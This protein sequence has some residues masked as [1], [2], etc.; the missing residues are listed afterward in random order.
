MRFTFHPVLRVEERG[1]FGD[2]WAFTTSAGS[3]LKN[4][5]VSTVEGVAN[6]AKGGYKLATDGEAREKAWETTK[7][8]ASKVKDY[9]SKAIDDPE[10]ALNDARAGA[11]SMYN[12]FKAAKDKAAAEGRS[13]E[14]W[15]NITGAGVFEVGTMLIPVGAASKLGKAGKVAD[16][17]SDMGK[18]VDKVTD[19]AKATDK[20]VDA[21]KAVTAA[22]KL[23]DVGS[24][25]KRANQASHNPAI[26]LPDCAHG[27]VSECPLKAK[28]D[29]P[30]SSKSTPTTL[31]AL[32]SHDMFLQ[33]EVYKKAQ[34]NGWPKLRQ[35]GTGGFITAKPEIIKG[36]VKLYRVN[37]S[38]NGMGGWWS[39]NP[40]PAT[41]LQWRQR[42]AVLKNWNAA[43]EVL[44]MDI[45]AGTEIKVWKGPGAPASDG[46]GETYTGLA[47]QI[48][49]NI[50]D[51]SGVQISKSPPPWKKP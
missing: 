10:K 20:A 6:L 13:A 11:T 27:P 47:E 19:V 18:A 26:N 40:P 25:S 22:N 12:E 29:L 21:K 14:F 38:K 41:E 17:V 43:D 45:P 50:D 28:P 33:T 35:S 39:A 46:F 32:S 15:G 23:E 4:A 2:A 34:S 24:A 48:A 8:V 9:G 49:I 36:P 30:N 37:D 1:F 42:D 3:G 51:V 16:K 5:A 7:A 31:P 44:T